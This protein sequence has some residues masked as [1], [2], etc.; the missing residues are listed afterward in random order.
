M[1]THGGTRGYRVLE[2]TRWVLTGVLE[3]T[4]GVLRHGPARAA[5][6]AGS[7]PAP[8]PHASIHPRARGV[9]ARACVSASA[10]THARTRLVLSIRCNGRSYLKAVAL[11]GLIQR[12]VLS[13][14]RSYPT[15]GLIQRP[16]LSNGRSYPT[17][18]LIQR[19]VLSVPFGYRRARQ[20]VSVSFVTGSPL[21]W[22]YSL[23]VSTFESPGEAS[24]A[25]A[26]T[27]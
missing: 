22:C 27:C 17:A 11:A 7:T 25:P 19:M 21:S 8:Q 10:H 5:A 6:C 16:V 24:S 20:A 3:G 4:H 14:G 18:G 2:G 26:T 9:S 12:P 15:A 23:P 1:G 13:N